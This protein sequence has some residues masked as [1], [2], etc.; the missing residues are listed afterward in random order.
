MIL[1]IGGAYQGQKEWAEKKY[2]IGEG[3]IYSFPKNTVALNKEAMEKAR[4]LNGLENFVEACC[5]RNE[6]PIE[7]LKEFKLEEK[8]IVALD[9]SQGVVPIDKHERKLREMN[10]RTLIWLGEKAEEVERVFCGI[11]QKLK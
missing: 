3:D 5:K 11:G 7:R 6:E 1:I 4:M 9:M 8:I 2:N 10:G